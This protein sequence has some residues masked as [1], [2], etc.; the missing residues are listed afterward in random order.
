MNKKLIL[1]TLIGSL[2]SSLLGMDKNEL[3]SGSSKPAQAAMSREEDDRWKEMAERARRYDD[4]GG[5][6]LVEL[7]GDLAEE[8]SGHCGCVRL[9]A[10]CCC[11]LLCKCMSDITTA[12]VND[13][14]NRAV[15]LIPQQSKDSAAS[16]SGNKSSVVKAD[17]KDQ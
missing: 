3:A 14:R 9:A 4:A 10:S 8:Y 7:A 11:F 5:N 1:I 13:C 17:N 6:P 12:L 2:G 15:A 16:S